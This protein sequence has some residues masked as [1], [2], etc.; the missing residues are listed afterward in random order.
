MRMNYYADSSEWKYLF[1]HAIDWDQIIPLY[2]P[3]FP[4]PEGMQNKEELL[5]FFEDLL[6]ATGK[7]AGESI[8]GRAKELDAQG[9]GKLVDGK[10]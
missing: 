1:R 2:Y 7:W 4:T 8:A 3:K 6:T 5:E 9:G 10:S